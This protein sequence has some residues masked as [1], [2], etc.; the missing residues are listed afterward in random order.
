VT[1]LRISIAIL[2]TISAGALEAD[3]LPSGLG[4]QQLLSSLVSAS[5]GLDGVVVGPTALSDIISSDGIPKG[6]WLDF[7]STKT[8]LFGIDGTG[9]LYSIDPSSD[10]VTLIGSLDLRISGTLGLS[11]GSSTLYFTEGRNLYKINTTTGAAS[12]VGLTGIMGG[13]PLQFTSA[14]V[15]GGNDTRSIPV[16]NLLSFSR[17]VAD[18]ATDPLPIGESGENQGDF[19]QLPDPASSVPESSFTIVLGMGLLG[20]G[21]ATLKRAKAA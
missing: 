1:V 5:N 21:W 12:L 16:G 6:G 4:Y 13:D 3:I 11:T 2:T 18:T 19:A 8:R 10:M 20:I 9:F 14:T 17:M 15:Y 7:G